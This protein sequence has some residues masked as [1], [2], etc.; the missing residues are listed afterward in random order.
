MA[1]RHSNVTVRG[2]VDVDGRSWSKVRHG[3]A[4]Q[5]AG[6]LPMST[7]SSATVQQGTADQADHPQ[8]IRL[9]AA[10]CGGSAVG[11]LL[12]ETFA[13]PRRCPSTDGAFTD[14]SG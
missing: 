3:R 13:G 8:R 10:R 2:G 6:A 12:A 5:H 1:E 11:I 14:R 7:A 4:D 9:V